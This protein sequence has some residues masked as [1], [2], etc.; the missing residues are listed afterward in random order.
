MG[1][2]SDKDALD[3][4]RE[5]IGSV[6]APPDFSAHAQPTADHHT[7]AWP[8]LTLCLVYGPPLALGAWM[9]WRVYQKL[10]NW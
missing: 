10:R 4:L 8:A 7:A 6:D 5:L 3:I 9:A 1:T 2:V